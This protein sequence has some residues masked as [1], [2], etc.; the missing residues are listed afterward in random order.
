[1]SSDTDANKKTPTPLPPGL[2]AGVAAYTLW[3]VFPIYFHVLRHVNPWVILCHRV[4]WSAAFLALLVTLRKEWGAIWQVVRS[5]GNLGMLTLGSLLIAVNWLIFIYAVGSGQVLESS[6]GYFINPLFSVALG[7]VFLG[8]RLRRLQWLAVGIAFLGVLNL[9][10]RSGRFPWI[11]LS[12]AVSFGL[13]GLVR[14]KVNIN[15]LHGLL[16]ETGVLLPA[17]ALVLAIW[18]EGTPAGATLG[19]LSLSGIITAV[20]LLLF[21]SAV[22]KLK[23]STLGFLQYIGPSL[24]FL[25][26]VVAFHE[27]MDHAKLVS[28]LLCWLAIAVYVTDSVRTHIPQ[29]VAD[30]PE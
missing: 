15:S 11:A 19:L 10:I 2:A 7:M 29:T 12:L 18:R 26:A 1:V 3:G 25:L 9:A 24:Q 30:R 22:R 27:P 23:L 8:E 20:P 13:Y 28:F 21:G 14:K 4:V 6:L 5:P 16:V 17:G